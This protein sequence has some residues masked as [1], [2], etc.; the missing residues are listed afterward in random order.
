MTAS[1]KNTKT[2]STKGDYVKSIA[3]LIE[4]T[5]RGFVGYM[6]LVHFRHNYVAVAAGVYALVT[7]G[8]IVITHFVKAHK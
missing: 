8:L 7:A 5:F 4:A 6:L 3:W 2:E 1:T